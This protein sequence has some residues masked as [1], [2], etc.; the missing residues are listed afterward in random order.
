MGQVV[1]AGGRVS[2][3]GGKGTVLGTEGVIYGIWLLLRPAQDPACAG[4]QS[5][6]LLK[7]HSYQLMQGS[8]L[9]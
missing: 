8:S 5:Q 9:N 3:G 7:H 1:G 6:V 2:P 4:G